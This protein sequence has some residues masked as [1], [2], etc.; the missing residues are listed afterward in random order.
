MKWS[1]LQIFASVAKTG[2]FNAAAHELGVTQPTVSRA[3]KKLEE[4]FNISL[5]MKLQS[6]AEITSYGERLL[7]D[8]QAMEASSKAI[9]NG[10][11]LIK[12][13]LSGDISIQS[14]AGLIYHWLVESL[15]VL[16]AGNPHLTIVFDA[17]ATPETSR[18]K[19]DFRLTYVLYSYA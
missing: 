4:E 19:S 2:S 18:T 17:N 7:D 8:L 10:V 9:E 1:D 5:F 11:K 15:D 13:P 12:E 6:G 3:I 14:T 16:E